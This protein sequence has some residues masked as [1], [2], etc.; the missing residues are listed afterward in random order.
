MRMAVCVCICDADVRSSVL[1]VIRTSL[2]NTK[3]NFNG[4]EFNLLKK[5]K[6]FTFLRVH[7]VWIFYYWNFTSLK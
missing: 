5:P 1:I 7:F 2:K 6:L 4:I 3:I